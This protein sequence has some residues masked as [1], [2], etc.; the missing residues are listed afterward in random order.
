MYIPQSFK[1]EDEVII[2]TFIKNNPFAILTSTHNGKIIATHLPI[3]RLKDGK[4]YGHIAKANP[5]SQI[6]PKEEVCLIFSCSI[7]CKWL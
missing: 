2:E 3:S 7:S 4:L 1:I 5:Q 6:N